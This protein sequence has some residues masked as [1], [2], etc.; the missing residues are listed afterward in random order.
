[1]PDDD[2]QDAVDPGSG[3]I[4]GAGANNLQRSID[5]LNYSVQRLMTSNAGGIGGGGGRP[6]AVI[7]AGDNLPVPRG[8]GSA[9]AVRGDRFPAPVSWNANGQAT[10]PTYAWG[11]P[12]ANPPRVPP[13]A[14]PTTGSGW[15]SAALPMITKAGSGGGGGGGGFNLSSAR[16]WISAAR[17]FGNNQLKQALP[18]DNY[19]QWA[20]IQQGSPYGSDGTNGGNVNSIRK[21][22]FGSQNRNN[23]MWAQNVQD[24]STAAFTASRDSGY[25]VL[26]P[27][28]RGVNSQFSNYLGNA[29]DL[30]ILN[31][32]MSAAS[33]ANTVGTL[34]STRG[35]YASMMFGYKPVLGPGG[36]VDRS[37]LGGFTDSVM[38]SAY[39]KNSVTSQ[40]LAASLGQNGV[41]N[42]N[43][44]AYVS[45]AG[46]NQQT[47]QQLE[48][49]IT[50]RNTARQHGL[51][52]D[53]FDALLSTYENGGA[54]G[55]AAGK[56]LKKMGITN[57]ILQSQKDVSAS[58][59]ENTSDLLDSFGPAIKKANEALANFYDLMNGVVNLPGVKQLVGYT[60]ALGAVFG[61]AASTLIGGAGGFGLSRMMSGGGGLGG[62]LGRAG[63]GA[64]AGA[65]G[66][67]RAA[68]ALSG[69]TLALGGAAVFLAAGAGAEHWDKSDNKIKA[70]QQWEKE[71]N[72]VPDVNKLKGKQFLAD[73]KK[74]DKIWAQAQKDNSRTTGN[75]GVG[76]GAASSTKQ[77]G[78]AAA[79]NG[80]HAVNGKSAAGAINSALGELGKP[81]QWG[82]TGPD[83]WDCSGLMQH[84]YASIGVRIPRTSEQQ[85][86]VGESVAFGDQ[87][88]GDLMFPYAGHV[89]MYLGNGKIVEAPRTGENVRTASVS[90]YGKYAAIR[91]IV[92]SV[93]NVSG[94]DSSAP[95][96]KPMADN[97]GG[98]AGSRV[99]GAGNY[100]SSEEVDT[101]QAALSSVV[102]ALGSTPQ[103]ASA[104]SP[105]A[106]GTASASGP[107]KKDAQSVQ[108][109]KN[110]GK[111]L[112]SQLY[113]WTGG[114]W[115]ALDKLFTGESNWRWWADN[116]SSHAYGIVQALPGSKMASMGKDWK[117]NPA[118]QLKWVDEI[119]P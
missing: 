15:I 105:S 86:G 99:M 18:M 101:I 93:G 8:P 26:Q 11:T 73:S 100:G 65:G 76:G 74:F 31:P 7:P 37:A 116:P 96:Q 80:G 1:M 34:S 102:G 94:L 67:G 28:T 84:A 114:E 21:Y 91:R 103:S 36:Q 61:G 57:S 111:Q 90:E 81:Y 62:G 39:G 44:Q 68:T 70:F 13:A 25:Q 55:D 17:T 40:Q 42:S 27:G 43:I 87:R 60:G 53:K 71:V 48:D 30:A 38:R 16:R 97:A 112:A 92:G 50:G 88:P 14:L 109:S 78:S 24:A 106:P 33:A 19:A 46:G 52:G 35:L 95:S 83:S 9:V 2:G 115:D 72:H 75:D 20:A 77:S 64:A 89:V 113:N 118:T 3:R 29:K 108:K 82:G 56:Q 119:H 104:S 23:I 10:N 58:K 79:S 47:V 98:N 117:T 4:I 6:P 69:S 59:A 49:Y 5:Q 12:T 66:V 51:S 107:W 85:M 22:V 32:M 41:L 45:A 54:A 110:L 63:V